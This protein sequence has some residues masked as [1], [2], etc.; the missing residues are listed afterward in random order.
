MKTVE[1]LEWSE[2]GRT[3]CVDNTLNPNFITKVN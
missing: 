2:V 1:D 3:E